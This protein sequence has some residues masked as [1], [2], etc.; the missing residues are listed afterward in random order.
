V[1]LT[2][3]IAVHKIKKEKSTVI[4]EIIQPSSI[5]REKQDQDVKSKIVLNLENIA[6]D[7]K[8]VKTKKPEQGLKKQVTCNLD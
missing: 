8:D 5:K 1:R 6:S 2:E 3:H 4:A 7:R